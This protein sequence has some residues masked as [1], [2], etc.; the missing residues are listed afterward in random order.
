[1]IITKIGTI[2]LHMASSSNIQVSGTVIG[3]A[4][5]S[6]SLRNISGTQLAAGGSLANV[7]TLPN[8]D[9][10]AGMYFIDYAHYSSQPSLILLT[11]WISLEISFS[12]PNATV[13]VRQITPQHIIAISTYTLGASNTDLDLDVYG[14]Q[15][16]NYIADVSFQRCDISTDT[17]IQQVVAEDALDT[18]VT[19]TGS[20]VYM[21]Y[22]VERATVYVD[23]SSTLPAKFNAG[24][25]HTIAISG[26]EPPEITID[27]TNTQ[28]PVITP[29][30]GG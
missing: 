7:A 13:R 9:L 21:S 25:V 12:P 22:D 10:S 20:D 14:I 17:V 26:Q 2:T 15:N 1:M 28:T 19:V 5:K 24:S 6:Y 30:T 3:A 4:T 29:T 27:Y 11:G 23:N 18:P 8:T 16:K